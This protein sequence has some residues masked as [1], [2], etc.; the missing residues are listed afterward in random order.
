VFG[1]EILGST[2]LGAFIEFD[3]SVDRGAGVEIFAERVDQLGFFLVGLQE[4]HAE[5][6]A[7]ARESFCLALGGK[8]KTDAQPCAILDH[9]EQITLPDQA[10]AVIYV[11]LGA[12]E[13]RADNP[14]IALALAHLETAHRLWPTYAR[15]YISKGTILYRQVLAMLSA[16]PQTSS[17][18]FLPAQT[19]DCFDGSPALPAS[20]DRLVRQSFVCLQG[21]LTS[22]DQ[23]A[24]VDV[25]PKVLLSIGSL[26]LLL[27]GVARENEPYWAG[28][29]DALNQ[30]IATYESGD[31]G[32]RAR[33]SRYAG[34][35]YGRRGII[36]RYY[37]DYSNP[38]EKTRAEYEQSVADFR[39]ALALLE[40][41]PACHQNTDVCLSVDRPAIKQFYA[42]IAQLEDRIGTEATPVP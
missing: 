26:N 10:A 31:E 8:P 24:N 21:A 25:R 40:T 6:L 34:Y 37:P 13:G 38:P 42:E 11:F 3:P 15:P 2:G 39:T 1:E 20:F 28:A 4:Y 9:P 12:L 33:F 16:P 19:D 35:A 23:P 14:N 7:E 22:A 18:A 27:A 17:T 32:F 30:V 41:T 5:R 29:R 36:A